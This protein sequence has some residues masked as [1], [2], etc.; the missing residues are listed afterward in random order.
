M[1]TILLGDLNS[2]EYLITTRDNSG[3]ACYDYVALMLYNGGMYVPGGEGGACVW[4]G[5]AETWLNGCVTSSKCSGTPNCKPTPH[6]AKNIL[7]GV[8]TDAAKNVCDASCGK[9]A[10]ALVNKYGGAGV[11]NWVL[12]GWG[13]GGS[14]TDNAA[15]KYFC[16]LLPA[17][18]DKAA[19]A[20]CGKFPA[21]SGGGG[22]GGGEYKPC[23]KGYDMGGN[24]ASTCPGKTYTPAGA[25]HLCCY[26][27]E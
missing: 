11:M 19:S 2:W 22:G 13:A 5:W 17:L 1:I 23:D 18:G 27:P 25:N 16:D 8:I 6:G 3:N 14:G 9:D 26:T 12:P 20:N 21:G 24:P 7:L 4:E 10:I 15:H